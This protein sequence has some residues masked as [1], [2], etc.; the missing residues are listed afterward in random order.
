MNEQA[1][2]NRAVE[3]IA[4]WIAKIELS[5]APEYDDINKTSERLAKQLLNLV[6]G[7]KLKDLNEERQNFPAVDPGG[8]T[9]SRAS[10]RSSAPSIRSSIRSNTSSRHKF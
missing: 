3:P 1:R 6:H 4:I 9:K 5:H 7:L 10:A 8:D 2:L